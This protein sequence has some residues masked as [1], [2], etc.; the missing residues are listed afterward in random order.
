M[1]RTI[2]AI[3]MVAATIQIASAQ[4][5]PSAHEKGQ[6]ER[7]EAAARKGEQGNP[8]QHI[9]HELGLSEAQSAAFAPIYTEYRKEIR[10]ASVAPKPKGEKPEANDEAILA[11]LN[12]SLDSAVK[13]AQIRKAYIAKFKAVLTPAQIM[14]LYRMED[15]FGRGGQHAPQH[16]APQGNRNG[17]HPEGNGPQHG[18]GGPGPRQ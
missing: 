6:K 11:R 1:K 17:G 3:L 13:V 18:H 4:Q 12:E 14:K 8:M 15:S 9:S 16:G 7:K 10:E 2:M 5:Q